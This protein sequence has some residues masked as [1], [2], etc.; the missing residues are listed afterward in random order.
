[1]EK[2]QNVKWLLAISVILFVFTAVLLSIM[3]YP[4]PSGYRD[5]WSVLEIALF[6]LHRINIL[7]FVATITTA[8]LYTTGSIK[9]D[10]MFIVT[11]NLFIMSMVLL[12]VTLLK[13]VLT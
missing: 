2:E 8:T 11:V 12:F 1:L 6:Y 9:N 3:E 7:L 13:P 4:T 5:N 10:L